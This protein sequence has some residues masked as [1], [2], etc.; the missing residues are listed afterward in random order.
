M[1]EVV[2][3]RGLG[4][5]DAA[6]PAVVLVEV[7]GEVTGPL[8]HVVRHSP[9][10]LSWGYAGSGPADLARSLLVDA[11]G[12]DARC[13]VCDGGHQLV[14]VAD[15]PEPTRFDPENP[16]HVAAL[17]DSPPL[18][19]WE[20]DDGIRGDLPYQDYKFD[21]VARLPQGSNWTITREEIVRWWTARPERSQ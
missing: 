4:G 2:V 21:V 20:C 6:S 14:F 5:A 9:T 12:A 16:A 1:G 7:D 3:Y 11:L 17:G 10:G 8:R 19:C 18:D 15:A 13:P